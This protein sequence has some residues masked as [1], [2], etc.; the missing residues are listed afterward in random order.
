MANEAASIFSR[1]N[2]AL[3]SSATSRSDLTDSLGLPGLEVNFHDCHGH[4]DR[5]SQDQEMRALTEL[6]RLELSIL[7]IE[8]ELLKRVIEHEQTPPV[9]TVPPPSTVHTPSPVDTPPHA[10]VPPV[11]TEPHIPAGE[12]KVPTWANDN[13]INNNQ[14]GLVAPSYFAK[15]IGDNVSYKPTDMGNLKFERYGYNYDEGLMVD[16]RYMDP[17]DL[18][19]VKAYQTVAKWTSNDTTGESLGTVIIPKGTTLPRETITQSNGSEGA[20]N[21][22]V[23]FIQPDGKEVSFAKTYIGKNSKVGDGKDVLIGT[24]VGHTGWFG[25]EGAITTEEA[26]NSLANGSSMKH[27]LNVY[28]P[29]EVLSKG[30][31]GVTGPS[32]YADSG[33]L[34]EYN[35]TNEYMKMGSL[36]AVPK[37][38]TAE[39]LGIQTN[40]GKAVL[41]SFQDYGAYIADT[42]HES[43]AFGL[44]STVGVKDAVIKSG[45][46]KQFEQDMNKIMAASKV[47]VG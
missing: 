13:A 22:T 37:N 34:S 24:P 4:H 1:E 35:S 31:K 29:V 7:K 28:V 18:V 20:G 30:N 36:L 32:K 10:P 45:Q 23:T 26:I 6:V 3:F 21:S 38:V 40:M 42:T 41:K 46:E 27:A 16:E 12:N 43:G 33:Y 17:K 8:E 47:V 15:E 19:T 39:Q 25:N 44:D 5:P 11:I 2:H 14:H 9:E